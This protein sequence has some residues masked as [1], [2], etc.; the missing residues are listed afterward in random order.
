MTN[1]EK[2][3][4]QSALKVLCISDVHDEVQALA[5]LEEFLDAQKPD[6]LLCCGDITTRGPIAF[7]E[8]FCE[9]VKGRKTKTLAVHGNMDPFGVQKIL[10]EKK[11]SIHGKTVEFGGFKFAGWGGSGHTPNNTPCEYSE[12][13]IAQGLSK[14]QVDKNTVLLAHVP[15]FGTSAD[16][17]VPGV[18]IGSKSL[19]AFVEQ[20]QPSAVVC[21]HC[22]Q[23][24]GEELLGKT[25]VI[26]VAPLMAGRAA[27]LELPS[28]K[29]EFLKV[30][31]S[32]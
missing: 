2:T 10:V 29:C 13:E 30:K 15:P 32:F 14:M 26:K 8:Q 24:E 4:G 6:L 12:D 23:S 11:I 20:K 21:G 22:H 27:L 18:H 3:G 5:F 31:R 25:K 17:P 7:A 1:Q 9:L 19:R 16:S 28:L